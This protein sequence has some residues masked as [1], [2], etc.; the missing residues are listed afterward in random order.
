[1]KKHTLH[2]GAKNTCTFLD[3]GRK[4]ELQPLKEDVSWIVTRS[5]GILEWNGLLESK[6]HAKGKRIEEDN[7]EGRVQVNALE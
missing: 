6:V 4:V 2:D 3:R 1:M 7:V 5:V